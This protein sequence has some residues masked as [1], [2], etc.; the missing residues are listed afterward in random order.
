MAIIGETIDLGIPIGVARQKWNEYA[1]GMVIGSGLGPGER[2]YP[3]RWRKA[4]RDAEQ[5]VLQ[6][7]AIDDGV[8]RLTVTLD[9]PDLS[10]EDRQQAARIE[11][12]RAYLR[13]DL[14]LFREYSEGRLHL[15]R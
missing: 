8:T 9:F 11:Q 15:T 7:A 3:F 6:F 5:G 1:T 4:E 2:E 13:Y 14:D 10:N 12:L